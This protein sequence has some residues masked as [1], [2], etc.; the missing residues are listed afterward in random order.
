M[1]VRPAVLPR[2]VLEALRGK[3]ARLPHNAGR[4][5]IIIQINCIL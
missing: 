2:N 4:E 3:C 5:R 1:E